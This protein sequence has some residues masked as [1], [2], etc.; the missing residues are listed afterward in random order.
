[1]GKQV[2]ILCAACC[3]LLAPFINK[4]VHVDDP[5]FLWS[6]RQILRDPLR[7]YEFEVNWAGGSGITMWS[8]TKN[9]PLVSYW[10]AAAIGLWTEDEMVMHLWMWPFAVGALIATWA[11]ARRHVREPLWPALALLVSPAFLV[12]ATTLMADVPALALLVAGYFMNVEGTDRENN[13]LSAAGAVVLG[14]AS[15]AKYMATGGIALA[16]L[17]C[18]LSPKARLRSLAWLGLS[19][20]PLALWATYG[21]ALH[22]APHFAQAIEFSAQ[23]ISLVGVISRAIATLAF[24]GGG[25]VWLLV[26]AI[27]QRRRG[28][29]LTLAT[30]VSAS[31]CAAV[32]VLGLRLYPTGVR[33]PVHGHLLLFGFAFL[34]TLAIHLALGERNRPVA[35][36]TVLQVWVVA[37]VFFAIALNWTVNART[38]LFLMPP[39]AILTWG[40][41]ERVGLHRA[42]TIAAIGLSAAISL[43]IAFTDT[44]M[45]NSY[46]AMAR[47]L[48]YPFG[49][50]LFPNHWGFQ[51]YMEQRGFVPI[52]FMPRTIRLHER[53]LVV[54]AELATASGPWFG[55]MNKMREVDSVPV[56]WPLRLHTMDLRSGA[57]FYSSLYGPLPYAFG[58]D[59]IERFRFYHIPPPEHASSNTP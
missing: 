19:I 52:D 43:V 11:L 39:L 12:S 17:Y 18:A 49:Q 50:V 20:A 13:L 38:V 24:I 26:L 23:K 58:S 45:A 37:V 30:I 33:L 53:D 9:P 48:D 25:A 14:T 7:P 29:L 6:A 47:D 32:A 3:A 56:L 51:Y 34:G 46:R 4:A 41:I 8:E 59:V 22:G 44:R 36:R 57:A 21:L 31:C 15:L 1:M 16:A 35:R 2:A 55:L 10:L 28:R 5:L 42:F 40:T 54:A 27:V